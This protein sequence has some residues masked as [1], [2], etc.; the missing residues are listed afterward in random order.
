MAS[1]PSASGKPEVW[2]SPGGA[3][4]LRTASNLILARR[5]GQQRLPRAN[6]YH[7]CGIRIRAGSAVW[8]QFRQKRSMLFSIPMLAGSDGCHSRPQDK[9]L[10]RQGW[11]HEPVQQLQGSVFGSHSNSLQLRGV[12]VV[13]I[14]VQPQQHQSVHGADE[15]LFPRCFCLQA[16]AAAALTT[17]ALAV[18]PAAQAAQ[19]V[20]MVAEVSH[21]PC[22]QI[23]Q[24][25]GGP[26]AL[27]FSCNY[28]YIA[29]Y[30]QDAH[31]LRPR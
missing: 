8:P 28:A 25:M 27:F 11:D 23:K 2:P 3:A 14:C 30:S 24:C 16:A 22:L 29:K 4:K 20:L 9:E 21:D 17:M 12:A 31:A 26:C 15:P 6:I 7:G 10:R 13:S 18:A 19:E 5:I 1:S